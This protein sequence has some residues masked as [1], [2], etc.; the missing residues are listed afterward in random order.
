MAEP[1]AWIPADGPAFLAP[2][3]PEAVGKG[4]APPS[5][6][7]PRAWPGAQAPSSRALVPELPVCEC[8][9]SMAG[10]PVESQS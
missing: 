3:V 6:S 5:F 1:A 2:G 9:W 4:R 7:R 8:R 10:S